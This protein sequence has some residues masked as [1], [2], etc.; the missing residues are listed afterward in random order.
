MMEY[1]AMKRYTLLL[2]VTFVACIA[3]A[4]TGYG[5]DGDFNPESPGIPSPNGFYPEEGLLI[6]DGLRYGDLEEAVTNIFND[7]DDAAYSEADGEL[8]RKVMVCGDL[9]Q[10]EPEYAPDFYA[11]GYLFPNLR[12]L[13]LSRTYGCG[14]LWTLDN[15]GSMEILHLPDCLEEI[16][17]LYSAYY[18]TDVYCY[19]ELPPLCTS[20]V[21][22]RQ[23]LFMDASSVTVHVP[24]SSLELYRS[25]D[26]W[27]DAN[28]VAME[29]G[30]GKINVKMPDGIELGRYRNM[31]LTLTDEKTGLTTRYVTSDRNYY[32]FPG[33]RDICETTWRV[34]LSNRFGSVIAVTS[35]IKP[36]G[37]VTDVTMADL[38][39][40]VSLGVA[41]Y[42]SD[43]K[44]V[45]AQTEI[46]WYDMSGT[47]LTGGDAL[48]GLVTGDRAQAEI[49]LPAALA[50]IYSKPSIQT[51]TAM[52]RDGEFSVMLEPMQR[53]TLTGTVRDAET[54]HTL[55]GISVTAIQTFGAGNTASFTA[56]T[57]AD[58][59]FSIDVLEGD[60]TLSFESEEYIRREVR[61]AS[62]S[63]AVTSI[64]DVNMRRTGLTIPVSIYIYDTRENRYGP[65]DREFFKDYDDLHLSISD[66]TT[67][68]PVNDFYLR[69]NQIVIQEE[70]E[71]DCHLRISPSSVSGSFVGDDIVVSVFN[72]KVSDT[73]IILL[74][75]LGGFESTFKS[76]KNSSVAAVLYDSEGRFVNRYR[77]TSA[78]L[79]VKGLPAGNYVLVTMLN[80]PQLSSLPTLESFDE[81]RLTAGKD[82]LKNQIQIANSRI[83]VVNNDV[84][85]V[86]DVESVK[87]LHSAS[88]FSFSDPNVTEGGYLTL[89]SRIRLK[90]TFASSWKYSDFRLVIDLPENCSYLDNSLMVDGLAEGN[91]DVSYDD[92]QITVDGISG[93][94]ESGD[95]ADVRL[96]LVAERNGSGHVSGKLLYQYDGE[97]YST[98]VGTTTY[99]ASALDFSISEFSHDGHL[100]AAG[101]C[102][103]GST[104]TVADNGRIVARK[105]VSGD[106]WSVDEVMADVSNLSI[107]PIT[108]TCQTKEGNVYT[109]PATTVLVDKDLNHASKVTMYYPNDF[110]KT[111]EVCTFDFLVPDSKAETYDFYPESRDFT[112]VIDFLRNDTTEIGDV[113]LLIEKESGATDMRN[114]VYDSSR[115]AW[116]TSYTLDEDDEYD[117]PVD[118]KVSFTRKKNMVTADRRKMDEAVEDMDS[119]IAEAN[120]LIS[121][122]NGYSDENIDEKVKA[123]E[124]AVGYTLFGETTPEDRMWEEWFNS[125]SKE[126]KDAEIERL[127]AETDQL[128]SSVQERTDNILA[129]IS[130]QRD[131]SFVLD[132]GTRMLITDCSGYSE[133]S[134][135]DAGFTEQMVDDGS[136]VYILEDNRHSVLVDFKKNTVLELVYPPTANMGGASVLEI[137]NQG[138]DIVTNLIDGVGGA[139]ND[140]LGNIQVQ[141]DALLLQ[142]FTLVT[143]VAKYECI[144]RCAD[145]SAL[146]K[147]AIRARLAITKAAVITTDISLKVAGK[148][149][150]VVKK[151]IPIMSYV[152][153]GAEFIA[154][155]KAIAA[156]Y[157]A[158]PV[159]CPND[160]A[161]ANA[162][163]DMLMT[164]AQLQIAFS[165]GKLALQ[166]S[167]DVATAS[168][169]VAALPTGGTALL[170]AAATYIAK[171]AAIF[172]AD[173]AFS[174]SQ[175]ARISQARDM[176][177]RLQCDEEDE[178]EPE[179]LHLNGY[180]PHSFDW[181]WEKPK[182]KRK[183]PLIDPSGYVCE[184][185]GSNRLEG[186]TAT[187]YYKAEVEDMYGDKSVQTVIWDAENYGQ[188]N[189]LLTDS[190]GMYSWMVPAGS[191]QVV[192]EK[193][194]YE[195]TRSPWLPVPP[196]QLDVNMA[197]T[198]YTQPVVTGVRADESGIDI[199]FSLYMK[200]STV[201]NLSVTALQNGTAV[202]GKVLALNEEVAFDDDSQTY[203]SHFKLTPDRPFK[204]GS[205]VTLKIASLVKS[206]AGI[207][208]GEDIEIPLVVEREVT[209]I[210]ADSI[211]SVPYGG[212]RQ[213]TVRVMPAEAA[214]MKRVS[215]RVESDA[216][217]GLET[218]SVL[219]DAQGQAYINI[220][221][222]LPGTAYIYFALDGTDYEGVSVVHVV[223][224]G[225]L[226]PDAPKASIIGGTYVTPGTQVELTAQEGCT[227]WYT[228]DGSCPCDDSSNIE[229]TGPITITADTR[230]RAMAVAPDGTES[231]VVT[232]T[233]FVT[234]VSAPTSLPDDVEFIFDLN[235]RR[236]HTVP[237]G[238][239]IQGGQK[240]LVQ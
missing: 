11:M 35:G 6:L 110:S 63:D 86:P 168:S 225:S 85:P 82:Y 23:P 205:E 104:V 111:T 68:R 47:R 160:Q 208:L 166:I 226:V 195:T 185:V 235:G 217:V 54:H 219:L 36:E 230:L 154:K 55:P 66:Y 112:F 198:Q 18:L 155:F 139:L 96:C 91:F 99:Q 65:M 22:Y 20:Y 118:V 207:A 236:L 46:A 26:C 67:G 39:P 174:K 216:I 71:K 83:T 40:V 56:V 159:P 102:V 150:G 144:L 165:S 200:N 24:E 227:I 130:T 209:S 117:A 48:G 19:A 37:D 126:E 9:R 123:Y 167:S 69:Y 88:T 215:I 133:S 157:M 148:L 229:Y 60:L 169:V 116:V 78:T 93:L 237:S 51:M 109:S 161:A 90:P 164:G 221:G 171:N 61:N 187:C 138:I 106:T 122:L 232:F 42:D 33:I 1:T 14:K 129:G 192:Y 128:V 196:P 115:N 141:T 107:H 181:G 183:R 240:R 158:I 80:D 75:E 87:I 49:K 228:L 153:I 194:G 173:W 231:E 28:I 162:I 134:L 25:A 113:V 81:M 121:I 38:R 119:F 131:N 32:V 43:K 145:V 12:E 64:G 13:D 212:S 72:G 218:G 74:N 143:N 2:A 132:N 197:L 211:V 223:A 29:S 8:V 206:Y 163:S 45:T 189:P 3:L 178:P 53:H 147:I 5:T 95:F 79:T 103:P 89:R 84:V 101:T 135:L 176:L 136:K 58:G 31:N 170:V 239:Y 114:A 77:H 62:P 57:D 105:T 222:K 98:P 213:L 184:A 234:S 142:Q 182:T 52:E 202:S 190:Q 59:S 21:E 220:T 152:S 17:S 156:L 41:V 76:T 172:A 177:S 149:P 151:I 233:W 125:L 73:Q 70:L 30:V 7:Y 204:P 179:P 201:S 94:L 100:L 44:D 146:Q 224:A 92:G 180:V 137:C 124:E 238:V 191:W 34:T 175:D 4:Q 120:S 97:E 140:I 15:L 16:G 210:G 199:K 50:R 188:Q 10:R 186:V 214:A 27:K 203:A 108:V 127:M 193:E